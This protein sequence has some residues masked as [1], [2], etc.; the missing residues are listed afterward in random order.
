[1]ILVVH[2]APRWHHVTKRLK[3][4][5]ADVT[6]RVYRRNLH[7]LPPSRRWSGL[8]HTT[9]VHVS[10]L[11]ASKVGNLQV[12]GVRFPCLSGQRLAVVLDHRIALGR[13]PPRDGSAIKIVRVCRQLARCVKKALVIFHQRDGHTVFAVVGIR[14]LVSSLLNRRGPTQ[15]GALVV[16]AVA[17]S[18]VDLIAR[19]PPQQ[20]RVVVQHVD[21]RVDRNGNKFSRATERRIA[22]FGGFWDIL[23]PFRVAN[24]S[25]VGHL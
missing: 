4:D 12:W 6:D 14:L 10:A 19:S 13:V 16:H 24:T 11:H 20:K 1:M 3:Y 8:V 18:V 17:I 25:K 23:H 7:V 5:R 15:I 22:S 9:A 21:Q 2:R